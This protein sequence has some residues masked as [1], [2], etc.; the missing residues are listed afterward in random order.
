MNRQANPSANSKEVQRH[1]QA[2][3]QLHHTFAFAPT[4]Q[5]TAEAKQ[6]VPILPTP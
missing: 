3:T 1:P 2:K 5:A 4:A 6:K